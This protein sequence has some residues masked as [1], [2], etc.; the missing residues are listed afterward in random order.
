[1]KYKDESNYSL[2]NINLKINPNEKIGVIG[3]TGAV[4]LFK[5]NFLGK[6]YFIF[7]FFKSLRS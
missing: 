6:I 7:K 3:R 1:M 5:I 2:K 4:Y